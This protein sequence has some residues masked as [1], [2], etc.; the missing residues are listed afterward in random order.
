MPDPGVA[1]PLDV[2]AVRGEPVETDE[3]RV[4][5]V[6]EVVSEARAVALD[7]PIAGSVPLALDI[8]GIVELSRTYDRQE[9]RLQDILDEPLAG[10]R[11]VHLLSG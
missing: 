4:E 9:P 5:L 1:M 2:E 6:T 11:D 10:G 3:R 8:D 7:E